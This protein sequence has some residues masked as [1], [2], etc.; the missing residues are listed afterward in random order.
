VCP[1]IIFNNY[2]S[3]NTNTHGGV[4]TRHQQHTTTTT[5]IGGGGAGQRTQ[6]RMTQGAA[7]ADEPGSGGRWN[8]GTTDAM[9]L[10]Q[11]QQGAAAVDAAADARHLLLLDHSHFRKKFSKMTKMTVFLFQI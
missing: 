7:A 10:Q 6:Q 2:S 3:I 8:I 9:G 4:F 1:I 11:F 5:H